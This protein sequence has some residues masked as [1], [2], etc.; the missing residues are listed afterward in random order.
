MI[1]GVHI[2]NF[3]GICR[4]DAEGLGRINLFIGK[5]D[6]CKSTILEAIHMTIKETV[7]P[8]LGES[9]SRRTDSDFSPRELW[10]NYDIEHS[11]RIELRFGKAILS[12]AI[13]TNANADQ[14]NAYLE[15][16]IP[17]RSIPKPATRSTNY[18]KGF[19]MSTASG[20]DLFSILNQEGMADKSFAVN[21]NFVDSSSRTEVKYIESLLGS[22]KLQSLDTDFGKFVSDVFQTDSNWEFIP[23]PD[24]PS[25][26]R[27]VLKKG[28][29]RIFLSGFGDGIRFCMILVALTMMSRDTVLFIEEIESN[30]HPASLQKII[31]FLVETSKKNN[32]Q[33]LITTH[34]PYVM[35][36]FLEEANKENGKDQQ[37]LQIFRVKRDIS[38]GIVE[39]LRR[40]EE[41]AAEFDTELDKDLFVWR[42]TTSKA[43]TKG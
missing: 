13:H 21:S 32:L 24:F 14:I 39:C 35:N 15:V 36:R 40:T 9:L 7:S 1:S 4:S 17:R 22:L 6:S 5:N 2:E 28:K 31:R 34:S 27:V 37:L 38:T 43:Q 11:I 19:S 33:L 23:H 20:K 16:T 42:T 26:Y 41:N 25:Q 18:S 3:K 10:F 29:S 12:N 30:Q 8:S